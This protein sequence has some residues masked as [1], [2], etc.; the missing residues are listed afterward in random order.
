M[1]VWD[2]KYVFCENDEVL[3]SPKFATQ[4]KAWEWLADNPKYHDI[5]DAGNLTLLSW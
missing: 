4:S 5:W 2:V 3:V 1:M